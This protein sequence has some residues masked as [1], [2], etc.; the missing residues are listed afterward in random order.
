VQALP[1][2]KETYVR[3]L[4]QCYPSSVH[5]KQVMSNARSL[6]RPK[7]VISHVGTVREQLDKALR[8]FYQNARGPAVET[9]VRRL[10]EECTK[11]WENGR[12]LCDALRSALSPPLLSLQIT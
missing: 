11:F 7:N 3:D 5:E 1:A 2:A 9:Y 10:K 6:S 8:Y 4:P 12:R